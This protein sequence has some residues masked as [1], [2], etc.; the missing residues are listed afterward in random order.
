MKRLCRFKGRGHG[1]P[2]AKRTVNYLYR[3]FKEIG[4]EVRIDTFPLS[5]YRLKSVRVE[6]SSDKRKWRRLIEGEEF[7]PWSGS[8]SLRGSWQIDTLPVKNGAWI[9]RL[10]LSQ[11]LPEALEKQVALLVLLLPRLTASVSMQKGPLP[12]IFIRDSLPFYR[13]VRVNLKGSLRQTQGW[14]VSARLA[15]RSSDSAWV[16]GA[17]YDHLGFMRR[18]VFWGANDN[19]SGVAFLLALATLLRQI[20]E[21]PPYDVWF[22]AFGAE[23]LGLLGSQA[24]VAHPPL[25][26]SRLRGMLNFDLVGFGEKG[27]AVVGAPDHPHLWQQIDSL[28]LDIGWQFPSLLLRPMTPN[29]DQYPF[30]Q[31]GVP[32]LFLYLE[33]GPGFYH[34]IHDRPETLSWWGA[35]SLMRWVQ[36]VLFLP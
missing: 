3:R 21:K 1:T 6:V 36:A 32:S 4:L 8:P 35:Y 34:D 31:K 12:V 5:V 30:H 26:L 33:G 27:V 29:S 19:A 14:N 11:S 17:H 20:G 22:V 15:G 16:V 23:E 24:W 18:A 2:Y 25:P 10:S 13:Y 9:T 7:I 28:R